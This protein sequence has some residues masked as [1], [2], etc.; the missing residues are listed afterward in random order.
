MLDLADVSLG[1]IFHLT[2]YRSP[3]TVPTPFPLTRFLLDS[4]LQG[5]EARSARPFFPLASLS[6]VFHAIRDPMPDHVNRIARIVASGGE[7]GTDQVVSLGNVF[8]K[9]AAKQVQNVTPEPADTTGHHFLAF[10]AITF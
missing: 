6:L 2:M 5:R 8:Q 9:G 3:E 4:T 10:L 1:N 7:S